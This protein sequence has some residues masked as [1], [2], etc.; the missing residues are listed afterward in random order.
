MTLKTKTILDPGQNVN[1][2]FAVFLSTGTN[3]LEQK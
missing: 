1:D 2:Y 3:T